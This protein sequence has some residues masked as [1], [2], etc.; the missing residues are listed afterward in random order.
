[1][2]PLLQTFPSSRA[3]ATALV[4]LCAVL[5]GTLTARHVAPTL[6]HLAVVLAP[7]SSTMASGQ[8]G[9][10]TSGAT[11]TGSVNSGGGSGSSFSKA[12]SFGAAAAAT[13]ATFF[14]RSTAASSTT[15]SGTSSAP[16]GASVNAG[17]SE[18]GSSRVQRSSLSHDATLN[19]GLQGSNLVQKNS[20]S[21]DDAVLHSE[22]NAEEAVAGPTL[23]NSSGVAIETQIYATLSVLEALVDLLPK[24]F[25][26]RCVLCMFILINLPVCS[27]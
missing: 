7:A 8:G 27:F 1:M 18:H 3:V 9:S 21:C 24:E 15:A 25:L 16:N 20:T 19:M 5:G 13:G 2:T 6:L 14:S 17:Q 11:K 22:A 23:V 4:R 26:P 12:S 10:G